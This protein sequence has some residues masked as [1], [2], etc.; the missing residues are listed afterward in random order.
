MVLVYTFL[1]H[2]F[3]KN[4]MVSH[5]YIYI[6][7]LSACDEAFFFFLGLVYVRL[8]IKETRNSKKKKLNKRNWRVLIKF[9]KKKKFGMCS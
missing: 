5:I 1:N 7:I 8:G 2:T 4:V 9:K 3:L 6:Y